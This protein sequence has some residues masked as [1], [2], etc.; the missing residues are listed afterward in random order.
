MAVRQRARL[1]GKRR[2]CLC[3]SN[4]P[5]TFCQ[6][7]RADLATAREVYDGVGVKVPRAPTLPVR[8]LLAVCA[9]AAFATPNLSLRR[10]CATF[11]HRRLMP[12]WRSWSRTA[13][14]RRCRAT[15]AR[16]AKSCSTRLTLL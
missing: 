3:S 13:C 10:A 6:A 2:R 16:T 4:T 1:A 12:S 11:R 7:L 14:A 9:C 5:W 8:L 15:C